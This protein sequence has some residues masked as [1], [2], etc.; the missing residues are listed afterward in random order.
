MNAPR[1]IM[2]F[3]QPLVGPMVQMLPPGKF[4]DVQVSTSYAA[5]DV[6]YEAIGYE[7]VQAVTLQALGEEVELPDVAWHI[8]S[9]HRWD[10]GMTW[11][12]YVVPN[13]KP[14]ALIVAQDLGLD[15][16]A[17]RRIFGT[18]DL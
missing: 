5:L 11:H 4:L 8:G 6:W 1:H 9:A 14:A 3:E 7:R 12:L 10:V 2:R 13:E 16:E 17:L 18:P 15:D